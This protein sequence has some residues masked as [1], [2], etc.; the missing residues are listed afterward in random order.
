ME[1]IEANSDDLLENIVK[2]ADEVW[3]EHYGKIISAQ[4]IEYML[5]KFQSFNAIKNQISKEKYKYF[6][7][8]TENENFEGFFAIAP[9]ADN[10]FLS[11]I[12]IRKDSRK[13][14]YAKKS[15]D[16]IVDFAKKLKLSSITLTVNRA[17]VDSVNVYKKIGFEIIESKD[18]SIGNGY[19]MNDY[20][21]KLEVK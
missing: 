5:E 18:V 3:R 4:Q 17:N 20:I 13:K 6:L 12:Y 1:I 8:K 16:F 10:L 2:I 19:E 11:K 21:M 9:K 7:M 14:G 15:F